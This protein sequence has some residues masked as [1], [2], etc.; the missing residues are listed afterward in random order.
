MKVI[1]VGCRIGAIIAALIAAWFWLQSAQGEAPPANWD[2]IAQ[3]KPWLDHAARLNRW[4]ATFTAVS[5]LLQAAASFQWPV[6]K[7]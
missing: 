2:L 1:I 6:F 7:N 5:V 4:A 3:L